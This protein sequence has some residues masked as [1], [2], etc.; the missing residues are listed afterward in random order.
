M[1]TTCRSCAALLLCLATFW[2]PGIEAYA[3]RYSTDRLSIMG[4]ALGISSNPAV[5]ER[6]NASFRLNYNGL[7]VRV[8]TDAKG[9]IDHIGFVL[10]PAA[11]RADSTNHK[12]QE[13][14]NPA[15]RFAERRTLETALRLDRAPTT[16]K[17]LAEDNI[18][19]SGCTMKS[20]PT[21]AADTAVTSVTVSSN[22]I[23]YRVAWQKS[24]KEAFAME[25]PQTYDL[26]AGSDM[27]EFERRLPMEIKD[28]M[29]T[30][31]GNPPL[32]TPQEMRRDNT[33][34]VSVAPHDFR[35]I[36]ELSSASYYDETGGTATPVFDPARPKLTAANL[37]TAP[38]CRDGFNIDVRFRAYTKEQRF[39]MPLKQLLGYFKSQGCRPYFGMIELT[40]KEL[41]GEVLFDNSAMGY[42]HAMKVTILLRDLTEGK[43]NIKARLVSYIPA[44]KIS[45]IFSD[46]PRPE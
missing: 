39:T 22:G 23:R 37:F 40:D 6:P 2:L 1:R 19:L 30:P 27:D 11:L 44:S 12:G 13:P 32:P 45:D 8:T 4:D 17:Q 20:L 5:T 36:N 18:T 34:G 43:G 38:Q 24:G 42:C 10:S 33:L 21:L 29:P 28:F 31:C 14:Q 9:R 46:M 35:F 16:E 41:V 7:P 25:F 26:L 3:L 15:L